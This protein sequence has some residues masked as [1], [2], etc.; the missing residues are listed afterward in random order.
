[1]YR[2]ASVLS[3]LF[4][5]SCTT[6]DYD[7]IPITTHSIQPGSSVR[8]QNQKIKLYKGKLELGSNINPY[9]SVLGQAPVQQ[10]SVISV[11]PSID[12]PVCE[13]QTHILG[14]S[15]LLD[16]SVKKII[17]SRDTPMA[18]KRFA[19]AAK[20]EN[21]D[22]FS[23]F[24]HGAFGKKSGLLMRGPELLARGVVVTDARGR[25]VHL[26]INDDITKMPDMKKAFNVANN[27]I[28]GSK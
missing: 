21:I 14:E 5:V 26:Q 19:I 18:Q 22:Y 23:D 4:L 1:M 27:L 10:V 16:L 6:V 2:A 7:A 11:V 12:T 13:A 17:I 9:L 3:V 8:K 24:A 15:K 28:K 20:L 25:I